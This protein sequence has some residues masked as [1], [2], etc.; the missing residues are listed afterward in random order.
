MKNA[1]CAIDLKG[2]RKNLGYTVKTPDVLTVSQ[3]GQP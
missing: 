2:I 1:Q 3:I